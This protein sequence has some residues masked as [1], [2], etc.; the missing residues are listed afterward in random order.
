M[1]WSR[2]GVVHVSSVIDAFSALAVLPLGF[3]LR[4]G[5]GRTPARCRVGST[6]YFFAFAHHIGHLTCQES[7]S[8]M[9]L[10]CWVFFIQWQRATFATPVP[11]R[12]RDQKA[13]TAYPVP[14]AASFGF[15]FIQAPFR[16][17]WKWTPRGPRFTRCRD[18]AKS[19]QELGRAPGWCH[20]RFTSPETCVSQGTGDIRPFCFRTVCGRRPASFGY[21]L[22]C[23]TTRGVCFRTPGHGFRL[24]CVQPVSIAW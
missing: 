7:H 13:C 4:F 10:F 14:A 22:A 2:Q 21:C 8:S 16:S 9:D 15:G 24:R 5:T 6:R 12:G 18:S 20:S 11:T 23:P 3:I 17:S 1:A 19:V